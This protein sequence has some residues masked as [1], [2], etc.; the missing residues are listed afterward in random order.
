MAMLGTRRPS[1]VAGC[2]VAAFVAAVTLETTGIRGA[3]IDDLPRANPEDVGM[4]SARL[5]RV[6]AMLQ[7]YIDDDKLAGTVALI[8]RHGK[9]VHLE[10]QGWR[11]KEADQLMTADPIFTIMSMTKP[12]VSVVLMTLFEEGH[13]VLDDPISK[14]LPGYASK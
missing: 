12:I 2:V 1:L 10:A 3:A 14:W 8:A 9:V 13:L 6:S 4:S 11:D 7:R 5:D